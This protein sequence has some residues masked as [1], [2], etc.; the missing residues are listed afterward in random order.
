M[1]LDLFIKHHE[2]IFCELYFAIILLTANKPSVMEKLQYLCKLIITFAPVAL[3]LDAFEIW[4][5]SNFQFFHS[6]YARCL[7]IWGLATLSYKNE[8]L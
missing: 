3:A 1:P 7:L 2:N 5:Q 4:Y 8:K 6:Y